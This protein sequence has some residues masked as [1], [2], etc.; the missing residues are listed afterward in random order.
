MKT[1]APAFMPSTI[2]ALLFS[3][4]LTLPAWL[5]AEE[6]ATTDSQQETTQQGAEEPDERFIPALTAHAKAALD[7]VN[8]RINNIDTT[9]LQTLLAEHP[10]TQLI[11]V[12]SAQEITVLGG[13]IDAPRHRNIMR[14]WLEV[15]IDGLIPDKDTPIVVYCGVNQ[16]SPFA[17]DTLMKL[18]Y[19]NVKNYAD[20][21]FA[22]KD[23]GLPV[24]YTDKALDSFL[25]S[26]PVEV[27]PGVWSAIG[28]TAPGTYDNSGHNNNLSFIITGEGVVVM[29]AGDNYL[30]AKA[31][32]DEIKQR[33]DQPVKYVL[34][35][36]GQ[37]HAMLGSNY[38]QE[39]GAKVIIH[40]DAWHE[41]EERG[42][43][44]IERMRRRNR[45][46]AYRTE[47]V[48]P[49]II[50]AE[51]R[52]DLS[53]GDWKIEARLLGPAH[54][55]GDIMMWLP[56][57][58]LAITGD[59]AFHQRL[60]PVFEETDTAAWL[61][62]WEAFVALEPEYIIPGHGE[63]TNIAEVTQYTKD[64]LIDMRTQIGGIIDQGSTLQ[65]AYEQVDSSAWSHLDTYDELALRNIGMIFRA[66][67]FE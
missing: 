40:Q 14:G 28:A 48:K 12:R 47:I 67:E 65:D 9:E 61:E 29:N 7:Q 26:K 25:Y 55:P 39:Q 37:G 20:G 16:R 10:E 57:K 30:L 60:L 46:K 53:L 15:Q 4:L 50:L 35:E 31:L 22:W 63:A 49:D 23:A 18:G 17:A 59:L 24:E 13:H 41:V 56:E 58:K 66:M 8:Q 34:L 52:M 44:I 36:N 32:H 42:H 19:R 27:I 43:E 64:Y 38:W 5:A 51:D 2:T 54:S 11:D 62:T 1:F 3:T 45:D 21:F 33:T 6:K